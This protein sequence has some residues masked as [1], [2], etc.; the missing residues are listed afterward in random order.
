M[1]ITQVASYL[2]FDSWTTPKAVIATTVTYVRVVSFYLPCI[3][4]VKNVWPICADNAVRMTVKSDGQFITV[5]PKY[6]E[7]HR[8]DRPRSSGSRVCHPKMYQRFEL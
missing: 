4:M 7:K 2:L 6:Q 1:Q 3:G 5:I 8:E